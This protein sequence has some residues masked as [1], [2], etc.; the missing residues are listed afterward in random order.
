MHSMLWKKAKENRRIRVWATAAFMASILANVLANLFMLGG[1]T[2]NQVS[3]K[4]DNLFVPAGFTFLIW[5]PIYLLLTFY[6]LFQLGYLREKRSKLKPDL[7]N[8]VSRY[9]T[10]TSLLN[11]AWIVAWHFEQLWLSVVIIAAMLYSLFKINELIR[12][13]K[14][15]GR[16][17]LFVRTPFSLYYGWITVATIANVTALVVG[18]QWDWD[19]WGWS[20]IVWTVAML[21][22]GALISL[23]VMTRNVDMMYGLVFVW[24]YFGIFAKHLAGDGWHGEY[25]AIIGSAVSLIAVL[26]LCALNL[27]HKE[28]D[29]LRKLI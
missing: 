3:D 28:Y 12:N 8:E 2:T 24:A 7:L 15:T 13:A 22:A 29:V 20:A 6:T 25:P 10:I 1:N 5:T 21:I 26:L 17:K 14:M 4:Y 18:V 9:F 16:E 27:A 23:V 11:A 19:G